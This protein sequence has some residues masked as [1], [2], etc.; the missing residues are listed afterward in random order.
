[1]FAAPLASRRRLFRDREAAILN[2]LVIVWTATGWAGSFAL[3]G[4]SSPWLTVIGVLVC[5]HTMILAAYLIH[6]AAHQTLFARPAANRAIGETMNFI[7]GSCYASFERIRHMHIR[8]HRERADLTC[9]DVRRFVAAHAGVRRLLQVLEW[10]YV[11][12]TELMMHLQV[13]WRPF[14]VRSQR[15]HLPRAAAM[16]ALRLSCLAALGLW[17]VKALTLYCVALL[18]QLHVLGFL[19]AFHHTFVQYFVEA[20]APVPMAGRDRQYEQEHTYSNLISQRHPWLNMLALN[21]PYHNAHH[22]RA[23]VP[24]YRLP[25]FHRELYGD[26]APAVMSV[27]DLL[28]TWHRNRVRSVRC[29]DFAMPMQQERL[30]E[31]FVGAH[32]VSFLTVV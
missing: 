24:W 1:M 18:V 23:S 16:L 29:E 13:V 10:A 2:S 4:S 22:Q 31:I 17:S 5:G 30:A 21:F 27:A 7:A 3:M 6:E 25:A 32:G 20:N 11:P 8:H 26:S 12:A 9:F 15:R 28:A 14:F 19:D